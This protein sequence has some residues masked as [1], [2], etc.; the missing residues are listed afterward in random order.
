MLQTTYGPYL[1]IPEKE[2]TSLMK[3]LPSL[4]HPYIYP[5]T[6]ATATV[7][8]AMVMRPYNDKGTLRDFICKVIMTSS[9]SR[10]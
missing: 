9:T 10:L 7:N 3:L 2:L 1:F 6:M 4:N 8:G 5:I